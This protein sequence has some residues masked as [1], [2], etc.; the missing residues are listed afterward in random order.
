MLAEITK[1]AI[2]LLSP[3]GVWVLLCSLAWCRGLGNGKLRVCALVIAHTQLLAFSLPWV[4]DRLLGDLESEA[5][6]LEQA[7]PLPA[8]V[9]A[10]VVLGGGVEGNYPGYRTHGDLNAA[11]D[12]VYTAAR[13]YQ[14]G[15]SARLVATGGKFDVDPKKGAEAPVMRDMLVAF[16]VPTHNILVEDRSRTTHE[17]ALRTRDILG[18]GGHSIALVTSAFHMG[19]AV[20]L[21]EKA[22]FDVYPVSSDIRVVP[23]KRGFWEWLPKPRALEEST[24]AIKEHLGRLQFKLTRYYN[25]P[26]SPP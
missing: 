3:L 22:G 11:G 14:Q 16:G 17:N 8:T 6:T 26:A 24:I 19:R 9:K 21:F 2:W 20:A 18:A 23:E 25:T 10:I 7:K 15:V 1:Y 4:S 12:R 13:L 5:R